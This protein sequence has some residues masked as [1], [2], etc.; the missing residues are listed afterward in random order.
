MVT[1]LRARICVLRV[2]TDRA[3]VREFGKMSAGKAA[4]TKLLGRQ[5][6]CTTWV[7]RCVG[8][9][10]HREPTW[11]RPCVSEHR[12]PEHTSACLNTCVPFTAYVR[13][14]RMGRR[15]L[16]RD[17]AV[18]S[19]LNS[20]GIHTQQKVRCLVSQGKYDFTLSRHPTTL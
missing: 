19:R 11:G 4:H 13:Q 5:T 20:R 18:T 14:L 16:C 15:H 1:S 7:G 12:M 8:P 6:A 9:L 2:C 3:V 10:G 17:A